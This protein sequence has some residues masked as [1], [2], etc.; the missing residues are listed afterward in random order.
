MLRARCRSIGAM[1]PEK[2]VHRFPGFLTVFANDKAVDSVDSRKTGE[3]Y[4]LGA[5][6]GQTQPT[7]RS[8][9]VWVGVLRPF[10]LILAPS[11]CVHP[12]ARR[13][14]IPSQAPF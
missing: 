11:G 8:P 1:A 12:N 6:S 10:R 7:K 9:Y 5:I 4:T 14:R 13:K 3:S 2:D